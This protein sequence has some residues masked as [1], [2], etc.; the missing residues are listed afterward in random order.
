M[1]E[2]D[3][4]INTVC[5][6][7]NT[8]NIPAIRVFPYKNKEKHTQPIITVGLKSGE[9]LPTGIA[10]YMGT[11]YYQESDTY[12]EI[13][14][15]KMDITL[16][17]DIYSPRSDKYGAEKCMDLFGEIAQATLMMPAGLKIKR[18]ACSQTKFDTEIN[19]FVCNTEIF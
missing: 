6:V 4:I 17:A 16:Q 14:G 8:Q 15:K 5:Q 3:N 1:A 10:E 13:F 11:K 18:L 19:M 2:L 12:V 7:L 9:G